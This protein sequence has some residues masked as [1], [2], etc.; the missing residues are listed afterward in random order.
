VDAVREMPWW[1]RACYSHPVNHA[2]W[3]RF[4]QPWERELVGM[5]S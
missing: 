5:Y 3:K 4:C 1:V 2:A